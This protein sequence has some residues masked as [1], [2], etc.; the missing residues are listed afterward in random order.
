MK[1]KY[2]KRVKKRI[3][4]STLTMLCICSQ[5]GNTTVMAMSNKDI[6]D[7]IND[8]GHGI[9][10]VIEEDIVQEQNTKAATKSNAQAKPKVT[11]TTTK[12]ANKDK[13]GTYS[14]DGRYY[15]GSRSGKAFETTKALSEQHPELKAD[16][17]DYLGESNLFNLGTRKSNGFIDKQITCLHDFIMLEK[18]IG[19]KVINSKTM[20]KEL[21][22]IGVKNG[23]QKKSNY[24][25]SHLVPLFT[26]YGVINTPD[27]LL[28]YTHSTTDYLSRQQAALML[29]RYW[30]PR[31]YHLEGT[32]AKNEYEAY[33]GSFI[34]SMLLQDGKYGYTEKDLEAPMTRL[35]FIALIINSY[36]PDDYW[37]ARQSKKTSIDFFTDINKKDLVSWDSIYYK[38][39]LAYATPTGDEVISGGDNKA[40]RI[41]SKDNV[42]LPAHDA[43]V[44]AAYNLGILKPTKDGKAN[45]FKP[46]TKSQAL[47]MLADA[48][49]AV[50]DSK[51]VT[52]G[53]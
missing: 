19:Y 5:L 11:T 4:I 10:I 6:T 50:H 35:E 27:G 1:G 20:R 38:N 3:L 2:L 8:V 26:Y 28:D 43:I 13:K 24:A 16:L 41:T 22:E 46:I 48:S 45:L 42:L 14:S 15:Y 23:L 37:A 25:S 18:S 7:L 47:R 39:K 49:I 32:T 17:D 12:K 34:G 44:E 21:G 31:S 36:F 40:F 29:G 30:N 51:G 53:K 9:S 33:V 52:Y